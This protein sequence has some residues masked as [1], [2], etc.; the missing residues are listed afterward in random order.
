MFAKCLKTYHF[1]K[2][3]LSKFAKRAK[4]ATQK[5]PIK[6]IIGHQKM[7]NF[8]LIQNSLIW[9]QKMSLQKF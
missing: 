8:I 5:F 2:R 9:V 3:I 4:M 1:L 6:I 7:R